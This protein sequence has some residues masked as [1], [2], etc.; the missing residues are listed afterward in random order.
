MMKKLFAGLLALC[1]LLSA[2]GGSA[3]SAVPTA[4]SQPA[5]SQEPSS[6]P[7]SSQEASSEEAPQIDVDALLARFW[8]ETAFAE[9]PW[10]ADEFPQLAEEQSADAP[11]V[12]IETSKGDIV[13]ALYPEAAP[14]AVENFVTHCRDGYY[15]GVPFH[16][17]MKDFMVQTGDPKGDGTGGESIW[18]ER[19][20]NE[21]S[22][23]L[24]HFTGAVAMANA[25]PHTNGSQ[26]Y[27]VHAS[28]T[29]QPE[30]ID[31]V[32][33]YWYYNELRTRLAGID[34]SAY[35]GEELEALVN[36]I[37]TLFADAQAKGVPAEIEARYRPAAEAYTQHGGRPSLDYG[38]TVFGQ[39]IEGMEVVDAIANVEVKASA[40]GEM[41]VPT[42]EIK[43]VSTEVL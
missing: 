34:D 24:R 28:D 25:G 39:V 22:D 37:N 33:V 27:I 14:L 10:A 19:F 3:A 38:Y 26:F 9:E 29:L 36:A 41:S 13:V 32:M 8:D 30:A 20:R 31:S 4:S 40:S 17:I 12:R 7:A 15:D 6:E 5:S 23:H 1:L 2:C 16:R 21:E 43:I 11:R 18:G 35:G 42:E